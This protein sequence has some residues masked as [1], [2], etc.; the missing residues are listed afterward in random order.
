M[1]GIYK[2]KAICRSILPTNVHVAL[3]DIY[4]KTASCADRVL[5]V[6]GWIKMR[7]IVVSVGQACNFR[8]RDCGNFAP[9]SPAEFRRYKVEDIID[10]LS[11][12]LKNVSKV[13][14]IQIQGGGT[15]P[16]FRPDKA[17]VIPW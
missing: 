3:G 5:A 17:A 14:N 1:K 15:V 12:I 2:V 6:L 7:F 10:S 8:C 13:V 4:N 9:I 11:S 16:L